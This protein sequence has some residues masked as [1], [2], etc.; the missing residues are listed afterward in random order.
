MCRRASC[1]KASNT[2]SNS[3]R[4]PRR[5]ADFAFFAAITRN[6]SLCANNH[7]ARAA[8]YAPFVSPEVSNVALATGLTL[9][10]A[11]LGDRSRP[12]VVM[13]PGPTDSWRS[14]EHVLPLL[15]PSVRAIA[16]SPRG[17]GDSDKPSGGYAVED[18][19]ADVV[20]FL[21][22]LGIERAVLAGHSGSCP[23]VRR[24]A[25]DHP[26]RVAAL[27]LE[28][29]PTTLRGEAALQQFVN[30]IVS[31]LTDPVDPALARSFVTDTSSDFLEPAFLEQLVA[32][33]LKVPARVWREMFAGLLGYDDTGLLHQIRTPTLLIWGDRDSIV[34]RDMQALLTERIPDATLVVYAGI[35]HTPRWEDPP[36][37][38][39]D[40]AAFV[41]GLPTGIG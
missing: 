11:E 4:E 33:V 20:P 24:V 38:A 37:F 21:D 3:S 34:R 2:T 15:L 31:G 18:L 30:S 27:V 1:A 12:A 40:V 5:G 16:V 28:A 32:E 14:Y 41:S 9:S 23:V 22:A 35:G 29:S 36:R 8:I 19:A 17:H 7:R 39:S 6:I 13:I 25:I 26:E 10:Y